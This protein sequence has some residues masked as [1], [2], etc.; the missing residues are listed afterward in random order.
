[1]T[2]YHDLF[3]LLITLYSVQ[4]FKAATLRTLTRLVIISTVCYQYYSLIYCI[5]LLR[6]QPNLWP[7]LPALPFNHELLSR[8]KRYIN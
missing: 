4:E 2:K 1:M 6:K 8:T 7:L 3:V 5:R